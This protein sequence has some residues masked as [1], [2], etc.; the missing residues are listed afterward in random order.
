MHTVS[1]STRAAAALLSIICRAL[2]LLSARSDDGDV[3]ASAPCLHHGTCTE[4]IRPAV[5]PGSGHRIL[6]SKGRCSLAQMGATTALINQECCGD[7]DKACSSKGVPTSCDAGCA[8]VFLPFWNDCGSL[9]DN[10]T[11]RPVVELCQ[12]VPPPSRCDMS[13]IA[14]QTAALDRECCGAADAAC[15]D[16]VPSSCDTGCA[17]VFLP[18]WTDCGSMFD[19]AT[20]APVVAMCQSPTPTMEV[21]FTCSCVA[22]WQGDV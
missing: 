3:C 4:V 1:S 17:E 21:D 12:A 2:L 8:Q 22:N 19:A 7:D 11:Y 10:A 20:Y 9:F 5:V 16:G 15:A 18:F 14:A 13:T 6:Q